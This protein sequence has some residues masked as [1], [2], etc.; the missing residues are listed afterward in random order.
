VGAPC[1][2]HGDMFVAYVEQVLVPE[3][4]PGDTAIMDNLSFTR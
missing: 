1:V 4:R 2:I 3:Q